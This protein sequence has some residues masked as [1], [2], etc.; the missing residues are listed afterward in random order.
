MTANSTVDTTSGTNT[1]EKDNLGK[2]LGRVASGVYIVTMTEGSQKQGLLATWIAQAGF[3]PPQVTV[4]VNKQRPMVE[5]LEKGAKFT[6][7]ILS[8][9]NM[10]VFKAFAGP[11]K[12]GVDRFEGLEL[13]AEGPAGPVF[14]QSHAHLDCEV[15]HV[16]KLTDHVIVVGTVFNGEVL[17]AEAEP[18]IHLRKNG[19]QY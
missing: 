16:V 10:D 2:A 18:M 7:N 11:A 17:D 19:F 15:S 4:A 8:K 14:A 3:E 13:K 6:I 5:S 1:T 12:D 9:K